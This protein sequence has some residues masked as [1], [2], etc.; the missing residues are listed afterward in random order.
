MARAIRVEYEGAWY[1]VMARGN[2]RESI[3][4]DDED[5]EEFLKTLGEACKMTGWEVHAWVLMG[6][7][8]HLVLRTPEANLV[9]GMKWLQNTYTRRFNVRH[10]L[11][12]RLF[13]DRYKAVLVE[14]GEEA[15]FYLETVLDYVHLNPVRARLVKV[16]EGG[17]I[18]D[19]PWSSVARGY[20]LLPKQRVTWQSCVEGLAAFGWK[21]TAAGRRKMIEHLDTRAK[22]EE[23]QR[24]GVPEIPAGRDRRLS[25]LRKGWYWGSQSFH[26]RMLSLVGQRLKKAR[27]RGYRSASEV[28]EHGEQAAEQLLKEALSVLKSE[29]TA[30][31]SWPKGD[32]R[33]LALAVLLRKRTT[34]PGGWIA[35]RLKM[36]SAANVSQRVRKVDSEGLIRKLPTNLRPLMKTVFEI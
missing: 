19:Y 6:N 28:K 20:A 29:E 27:A 5:R 15:S 17:S 13:G 30:I 36:G 35:E 22:H 9:A 3:Y 26:E 10:R 32:V 25:E 4:L 1:H 2:R 31:K 18:M 34:V 11:W 24:C 23:A 16:G 14:G 21:D 33:K 8:Y 12:G 7:H